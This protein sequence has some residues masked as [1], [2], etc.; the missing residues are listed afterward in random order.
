[1][2][3]KSLPI[4][5]T[6]ITVR[7]L[8]NRLAKKTVLEVLNKSIIDIGLDSGLSKFRTPDLP[9]LLP[10]EKEIT[11]KN[12]A[13]RKNFTFNFSF[14]LIG[15]LQGKSHT[16]HCP[17]WPE[18]YSGTNYGPSRTMHSRHSNKCKLTFFAGITIHGCYQNSL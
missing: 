1:M 11:S 4:N 14:L 12:K 10:M 5:N 13:R 3:K 9:R 17:S 7:L 8:T 18:T 15:K 6:K 2:P 16:D